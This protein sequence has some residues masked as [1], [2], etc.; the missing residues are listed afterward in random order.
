MAI[1][2]RSDSPRGSEQAILKELH[3]E[4]CLAFTTFCTQ[5][6]K[7]MIDIDLL[8]LAACNN[9]IWLAA[10]LSRNA[11][12]FW[13]VLQVRSARHL[14]ASS[15]EY[16]AAARATAKLGS[17]SLAS[18][19]SEDEKLCFFVNVLNLLYLHGLIHC[20]AT[21][22]TPS[23]VRI[24]QRASQ[25]CCGLLFAVGHVRSCDDLL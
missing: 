12:S 18:L 10:A 7:Q 2:K 4:L 11:D 23:E 20:L 9:C 14:H 15:A 3:S 8:G 24:K 16:A 1:R 5:R 6:A 21:Q 19:K 17:V 13:G 22:E 25:C